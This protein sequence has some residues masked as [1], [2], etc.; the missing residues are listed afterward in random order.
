MSRTQL[1][2]VA[3]TMNAKLPLAMQID[4]SRSDTWIR[5]S[6]EVLVGIREA[7]PESEAGLL[8]RSRTRAAASLG[9]GTPTTPRAGKGR[10]VP[11]SPMSPLASRARPSMSFGT[12]SLA[13]LREDSGEA[14]GHPEAPPQKK[15]RTENTLP[16]DLAR[17]ITR[18][19][20]RRVSP[21]LVKAESTPRAIGAAAGA[22]ILRS[23]SA[24]HPSAAP[25]R[26]PTGTPRRSGRSRT[27]HAT[28]SHTFAMTSTPKKR[29]AAAVNSPA[30]GGQRTRSLLAEV[31]NVNM[32]ARGYLRGATATPGKQRMSCEDSAGIEEI[33]FGLD[34]LTMLMISTSMQ[35]FDMELCS[36]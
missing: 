5:H 7:M 6:I 35:Y 3:T 31:Q 20:G 23:R 27:G 14:E 18:A 16:F 12:P 2:D 19:Q 4:T 9:N 36:D 21:L 34:G 30:A 1:L 11:A 10:N 13:V 24:P 25:P 32:T 8:T 17:P 29:S 33:T 28:K 22:R 15:R 26:T